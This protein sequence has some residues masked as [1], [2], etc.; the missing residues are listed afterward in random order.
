Q[1]ADTSALIART[2]L[3]FPG[4]DQQCRLAACTERKTRR[5]G[6]RRCSEPRH[7]AAHRC[8]KQQNGAGL[9]VGLAGLFRRRMADA[10][11]GGHE[12]EALCHRPDSTTASPQS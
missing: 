8:M 6:W 12:D 7:S 2:A 10:A 1:A 11:D 9:D 5:L 3:K 4:I